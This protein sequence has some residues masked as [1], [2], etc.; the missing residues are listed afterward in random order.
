MGILVFTIKLHT[1]KCVF[2][3]Y[4]NIDFFY[5]MV[6]R[7][8]YTISIYFL[9]LKINIV[10][11]KNRTNNKIYILKAHRLSW[12]GLMKK[13]ASKVIIEYVTTYKWKW[14]W[15][16]WCRQIQENRECWWVKVD[17]GTA[18]WRNRKLKKKCMG[19]CGVIH[20]KVES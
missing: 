20:H 10:A 19:S 15:E 13:R 4:L 12:F 1:Y 2:V 9:L 5:F 8:L 6:K 17:S 14:K 16:M 7:I 11:M 18:C 3:S